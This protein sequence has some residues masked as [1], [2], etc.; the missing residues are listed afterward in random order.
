MTYKYRPIVNL[1]AVVF[2]P[3][4]FVG[5][6]FLKNRINKMLVYTSLS[7]ITAEVNNSIQKN[8][9]NHDLL[10]FTPYEYSIGKINEFKEKKN[11]WS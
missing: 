7:I 11:N 6:R 8:T 2:N 1:G 4:A 9:Y 10:I 3:L 5:S